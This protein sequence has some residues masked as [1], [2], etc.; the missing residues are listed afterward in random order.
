MTMTNVKQLG[1]KRPKRN[2]FLLDIIKKAKINIDKDEELVDM[3]VIFQ[4]REGR[5]SM[6]GQTL[7]PIDLVTSI[8]IVEASKQFL[9]NTLFN[10]Y[11]DDIE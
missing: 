6:F 11:S 7:V 9:I 2:E 3:M 5:L 1:I 10:Q 4:T 8:G